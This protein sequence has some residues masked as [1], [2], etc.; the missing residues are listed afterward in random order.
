[1]SAVAEER[2]N[3]SSIICSLTEL[4]NFFGWFSEAVHPDPGKGGNNT[5]EIYFYIGYAGITLLI[6][7]FYCLL[8]AFLILNIFLFLCSVPCL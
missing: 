4:L 1:M 6:L 7:L 8:I 2:L 3:Y 5:A